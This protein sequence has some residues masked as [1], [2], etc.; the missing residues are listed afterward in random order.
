MVVVT[1]APTGGEAAA[2][3][4]E[5]ASVLAGGAVDTRC[6]DKKAA[7][8][9]QKQLTDLEKEQAI[10]DTIIE[11]ERLFVELDHTTDA[12]TDAYSE[13]LVRVHCVDPAF[14][15]S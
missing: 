2:P 1:T 5:A 14:G 4:A 7:K 8:P 10:A 13:S 9:K 11:I 3:A 12:S 15:A 6:A